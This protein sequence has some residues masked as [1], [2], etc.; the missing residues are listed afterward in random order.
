MQEQIDF[1]AALQVIRRR[2]WI[3]I[4]CVVVAVAAAAFVTR[5]QPRR[6]QATA[7][8][9]VT[10]TVPA[11]H[12]PSFDPTSASI[13]LATLAQNTSSA[14][15]QLAGTRAVAVDAA[16]ALHLSVAIVEGHVRGEAQ[17]GVQL[18]RVRADA[19][20]ALMASNIANAAANAL[21]V[22]APGVADKRSGGLRLDLVDPA[23]PAVAPVSPRSTLNLVLGGLAGLLIGLGMATMRERF[24]RRIRTF[25]DVKEALGVAVLGELPIIPRRMRSKSAFDRQAIPRIADPYRTLAANVAVASA[26]GEHQRLLITSPAAKEGKSTVASHLALSLAQEGEETALLECDLRRP[27]LHRAF[28]EPSRPPLAEVLE[29]TNGSLPQSTETVPRLKVMAATASE[30]GGSLSVRSPEFLNAIEAASAEKH[31]IILDCPPVLGPSDAGAIARRSDAAILIIA[32]GRTREEDAVSAL[33]ALNRLGIEVLGV[34][35]SGVRSRRRRS[36]Y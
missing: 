24:D 27:A 11:S 28:P 5:A 1:P 2:A 30:H 13:Q 4:L 16:S 36:Y 10:G 23:R 18:V 35:L 29:G 26:Q 17:P 19:S 14:Y 21:A 32:A 20:S 6:Y 9:F 33:T 3:V 34:V 25:G 15:A 22:R 8:L 31:L 7:T 12:S